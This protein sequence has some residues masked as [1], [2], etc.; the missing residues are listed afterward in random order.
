MVIGVRSPTLKG[1]SQG[2]PFSVLPQLHV[3]GLLTNTNGH[4][5]LQSL[6]ANHIQQPWFFIGV[7]NKQK[8]TYNKGCLWGNL[9]AAK[10]MHAETSSFVAYRYP[11]LG[12]VAQPAVP[13][14]ASTLRTSAVVKHHLLRRHVRG[15]GVRRPAPDSG[16]PAAVGLK[17]VMSGRRNGY[18]SAGIVRKMSLCH[19]ASPKERGTASVRPSGVPA[20]PHRVFAS[21]RTTFFQRRRRKLYPP[22]QVAQE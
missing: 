1:Y 10:Y 20:V 19:P 9:I 4:G 12:H 2:F 7:N 21:P 3:W 8:Q 15:H 16:A 13:V 11:L 6:I 18:M 22:P 17:T 14:F 5:C